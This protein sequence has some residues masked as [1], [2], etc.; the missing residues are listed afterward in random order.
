M[1]RVDGRWSGLHRASSALVYYA[2]A[3]GAGF[4]LKHRKGLRLLV[5][6]ASYQSFWYVL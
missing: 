5:F 6:V 1:D 3:F 4:R 2:I